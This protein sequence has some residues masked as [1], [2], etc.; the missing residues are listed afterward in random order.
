MR[1]RRG[2]R[3]AWS[4]DFGS[5]PRFRFLLAP[6]WSALHAGLVSLGTAAPLILCSGFVDR[7]LTQRPKTYLPW[8]A[9]I[10]REYKKSSEL[11]SEHALQEL[12]SGRWG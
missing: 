2:L 8:V 9:L 5:D 7:S 11:R 3:S 12:Q 6:P 4:L 10:L 1:I